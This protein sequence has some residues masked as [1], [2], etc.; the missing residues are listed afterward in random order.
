M[1][2]LRILPSDVDDIVASFRFLASLNDQV[3]EDKMGLL[4]D[5]RGPFYHN[6]LLRVS[7]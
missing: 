3:D 7:R 2:S 4:G 6:R 1:K 5:K